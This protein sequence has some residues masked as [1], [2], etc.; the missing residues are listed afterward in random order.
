M[1]EDFKAIAPVGADEA[2]SII[3]AAVRDGRWRTLVG[4]DPGTLDA[5][6]RSDPE[7]AYDRARV[8]FFRPLGH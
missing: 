1:S 5:F 2:G 6:V 4:R 8:A 7:G 3:L